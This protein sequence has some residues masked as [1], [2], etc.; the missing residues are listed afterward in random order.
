DPA[1]L[2]CH[3]ASRLDG[4]VLSLDGGGAFPPLPALRIPATVSLA[5]AAACDRGRNRGR[6]TRDRDSRGNYLT[7]ELSEDLGIT[8]VP[9]GAAD[10]K[11]LHFFARAG[12][13]ADRVRQ[14]VFAAGRTLQAGGKIENARTKSVDAGIVPGTGRLARPRLFAQVNEFEALIDEDRATFAHV[15]VALHTDDGRSILLQRREA[16]IICRIDDDV[17]VAK[18]KGIDAGKIARQFD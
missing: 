18:D 15:L 8:H 16:W 17:A 12:E 4:E 6:I 5:E 14:F 10:L 13:V 1:L 7:I 9:P 11:R 3:R 2:F